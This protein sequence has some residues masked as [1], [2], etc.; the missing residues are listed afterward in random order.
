MTYR[1]W[2]SLHRT[3]GLAFLLHW[4]LL[5][6][7][8]MALVFHRDI[9][10]KIL[11]SAPKEDSGVS[12][13]AVAQRVATKY[14]HADILQVS[15]LNG[16]MDLLRVRLNPEDGGEIRSLVFDSSKNAIV[17][18]SP[19]SGSARADGLL[20]FVY[21]L[22]QTL[23]L[24]DSGKTLVAVSGLFILFT[25]L[26]GY[27]LLWPQRRNWQRIL[28][29]KLAKNARTNM[30]LV[31]RAI[32]VVAGPIVI[33]LAITGAGMNWTPQIK[34]ALAGL[35]LAEVRPPLPDRKQ[36]LTITPDEALSAAQQYFPAARFTSITLPTN[37]SII[38]SIRLRQPR[39]AHAIFGM[40]NIQVNG[41]TG[42][43]LSIS[44]PRHFQ[45]GDKFLEWL[46]AVHNGEFLSLP[47]RLLVLLAGF[48]L[49]MLCLLGGTAWLRTPRRQRVSQ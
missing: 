42:S 48:A 5:A 47:G 33:T 39:E 28:R 7:T 12:L 40:T 38:Y 10:Q 8:G 21:R 22:H 16:G 49:F 34:S 2:V 46:F 44:D 25:T 3:I 43:I 14:P 13:D 41:A 6:L 18:D 17:G 4:A 1:R 36:T 31:H 15:T 30:T 23:L 45:A 24:G 20:P 9:E 29:P 27:R 35:G 19:L 26:A 37:G 32:G 11:G